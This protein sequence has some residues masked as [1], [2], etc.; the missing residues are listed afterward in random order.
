[1]ENNNKE[2]N[3]TN[4]TQVP[5]TFATDAD[6]WVGY[7][8]RQKDMNPEEITLAYVDACEAVER[9]ISIGAHQVEHRLTLVCRAIEYAQ[10]PGFKHLTFLH[11]ALA[12]LKARSAPLRT[13]IEFVGAGGVQYMRCKAWTHQEHGIVFAPGRHEYTHRIHYLKD[14]HPD[15]SMYTSDTDHLREWTISQM[16]FACQDSVKFREEQ[17]PEE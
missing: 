4:E 12:Q 13:P 7:G 3:R 17:G 6:Y 11:L 14:G 8:L 16:C 2:P 9:D 5:S 10:D 1:M 15:V